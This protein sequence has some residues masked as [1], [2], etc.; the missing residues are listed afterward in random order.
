[1]YLAGFMPLQLMTYKTGASSVLALASSL[2][3]GY[4][5][6][7]PPYPIAWRNRC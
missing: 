4:W 3:T 2:V 5:H 1:M 6:T 7:P